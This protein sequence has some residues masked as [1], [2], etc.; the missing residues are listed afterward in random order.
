MITWHAYCSKHENKLVVC[1]F[2][3]NMTSL[4]HNMSVLILPIFFR[5]IVSGEKR[6]LGALSHLAPGR[7][8]SISSAARGGGRRG[9]ISPPSPSLGAHFQ[10]ELSSN[11]TFYRQHSMKIKNTHA[12]KGPCRSAGANFR[13]QRAHPRLKRA[14]PK[15]ER[16]PSKA[17]W[18]KKRQD[19]IFGKGAHSTRGPFHG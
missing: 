13:P 19:F 9:E 4:V 16:G 1:S 11:A 17:K 15:S 10:S 18:V 6:L 8:A 5:Y 2:P 12:L 3:A 14:L 7:F